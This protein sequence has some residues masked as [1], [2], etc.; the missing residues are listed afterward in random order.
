MRRTVRQVATLVAGIVAFFA[1]ILAVSGFIA[2][3]YAVIM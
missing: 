3:V 1:L 2:L